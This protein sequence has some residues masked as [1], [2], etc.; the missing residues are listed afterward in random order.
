[1]FSLGLILFELFNNLTPF[2]KNCGLRQESEFLDF[3]A[4]ELTNDIVNT[5]IDRTF[6][7]ANYYML[8]PV[9]KN[10]LE[11]NP[12][13][14]IS[15]QDLR[16]RSLFGDN[17]SINVRDIH[18][19]VGVINRRITNVDENLADLTAAVRVEMAAHFDKINANLSGLAGSLIGNIDLSIEASPVLQE[20]LSLTKQLGFEF[21]TSVN[22]DDVIGNVER[23]EQEVVSRV[24]LES[25]QAMSQQLNEL[26]SKILMIR[27]ISKVVSKYLQ[28]CSRVTWI[29]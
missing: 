21:K 24:N 9:L 7:H 4:N 12:S 22:K 6:G 2:W 20:L 29:P 10:A 26:M 8:T 14:R 23:W 15:A 3:A 16:K 28:V 1:V 27:I 18:V 13:K 19:N 5:N 25:S 17:V 11:C